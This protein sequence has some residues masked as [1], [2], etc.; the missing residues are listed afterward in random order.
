MAR[1]RS[2]RLLHGSSE[3][4]LEEILERGLKNPYLTDLETVAYY[5]A[6]EAGAEDDDAEP[7]V[8]EVLVRELDHLRVDRAMYQE[9]ITEVLDELGIPSADHYVELMGEGCF[10]EP[11]GRDWPTSLQEMHSVR[12]MGVIP[13][14]DIQI[15]DW[16][17][18]RG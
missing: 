3:R 10:R 9:P 15:Y 1:R 7:V 13:P 16:P 6:D 11:S 2:V 14:R 4:R 17:A 5:F 18:R 12:Y 8:L